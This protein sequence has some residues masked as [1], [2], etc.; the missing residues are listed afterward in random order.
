[1]KITYLLSWPYEMGGTERTIITQAEAM[2][3]RH[4]VEIVGVL[5]SRPEPFFAIPPSVPHRVLIRTDADGVPLTVDDVEMPADRLIELHAAPSRLVPASWESA[6]SQL[7]DLSVSRW[8]TTLNS[9]V[10]VTTTPA[11]LALGSQLAPPSVVVVHQEHRTSE[12]RGSPLAPLMSHGPRVDAVAFLTAPTVEH[13]Q[14]AWG[15]AAPTILQVLNPLPPGLRPVSSH[16]RPL[17]V[18]AGRFTGEKRF[19]HLVEA[20]AAVADAHAEWTLRLFGDGPQEPALRRQV[21][22]LQLT[23]RVEFMGPS[24][25][26]SAEWAA[27]SI[28][29]LS[30]RSEGLPLVIQEAMAAGTP[31]VSYACPNGPAELITHGVNGLLVENGNSGELAAALGSLV[32]DEE[33]RRALGEA[34][35]LRA[36]AFNAQVIAEEWDGHFTAL[37][38]D[39]RP[40]EARLER[41]IRRTH[42]R[43]GHQARPRDAEEPVVSDTPLGAS[44]ADTPEVDGGR[45]LRPSSRDQILLLTGSETV[46]NTGLLP[47]DAR[48]ENLRTV[49]EAITAASARGFRLPGRS[50]TPTLVVPELDRRAVA[51]ALGRAAVVGGLHVAPV[52][53]NGRAGRAVLADE[54]AEL[55]AM[56]PER[57]RVYRRWVNFQ[58]TSVYSADLGCDVAFWHEEPDSLIGQRGGVVS[59]IPTAWL[60]ERTTTIVADVP[61]PELPRLAGITLVDEVDFP[62]DAVYTWVD[63]SDPA[64]LATQRQRRGEATEPLH[65][66]S[67]S[68][69]RYRSREELRFSLRSLKYFAP[70]IRRI[71]LVTAGQ[72][73][74]WLDKDHPDVTVVDH[75]DIFARPDDLP[76]FNSHAIESQLHHIEGLSEHFIYFNDDVFLGR[77]VSPTAFFTTGGLAS[78]FESPTLVGFPAGQ[79]PPHISAALNNRALLQRDFGRTLTNGMLHVAHPLRRSVLDELEKRYAAEFSGTSAHPFRHPEDLSITSSLFQHYAVLT[80]RAVKRSIRVAYVGLGGDDVGRRLARLLNDRNFDVFSIGD[81]HESHLPPHEVDDMVRSFLQAYWPFPVAHER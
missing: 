46:L 11:L 13:F 78:V 71:F 51:D 74:E 43:A 42:E 52:G 47:E 24:A 73:P 20:F 37:V 31:M 5:S 28:A 18:A 56:E 68:E 8:L 62:I 59:E 55:W 57:V 1:M 63:G 7:T 25:A 80:G 48:R 64:W 10:L 61:M 12:L 58:R 79:A 53:S 75:R 41:V 38:S 76:T 44:R 14:D 16:Q 19:D 36:Q 21:T 65:A 69:A 54:A 4:Q 33:R 15:S 29:A 72:V 2:S 23:D 17:I 49:V 35:R 39:V 40:G 81:F 50:S 6:F 34:A 22:R 66:E 70:W 30:S 32:A 27:A 9:D 60:A 45:Q 67:D 26:M 77:P 3:A